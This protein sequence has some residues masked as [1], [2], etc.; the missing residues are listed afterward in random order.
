[1]P[2]EIHFF[3][4]HVITPSRYDHDEKKSETPDERQ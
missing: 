4:R 3:D 1:M 2:R